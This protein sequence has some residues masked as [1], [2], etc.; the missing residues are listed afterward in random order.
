METFSALLAICAGNSP[1]SGE[2]PTQRPATRS[3]DVFFDQRPNKRLSK[4]LW[5]WWFETHSPPLWRHINDVHSSPPSAAYMPQRIRSTLF[6]IMVC[7]LFGAKPLSEPML[8]YCQ[9]DPQEQT[10]VKFI[11]KFIHFHS[12]KCIWKCRVENGGHF[13][14]A[15]R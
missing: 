2:F 15:S 13:V 10:S 3:F 11:S 1:V 12:R 4:Q 7:R 14:L 9:V 5:C 6:H 8:G